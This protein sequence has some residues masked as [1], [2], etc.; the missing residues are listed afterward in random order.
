MKNISERLKK[1]IKSRKLSYGELSKLTG[2]PKSSLQRYATGSTLKVPMDVIEKIEMTL[3]L[4][5]GTLMGWE[6]LPA[7]A[8]AAPVEEIKL[9]AHE[10]NVIRSYRSKPDMQNAVDTLLGVTA[11]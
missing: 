9:T 6:E 3:H 4:K 10:T 8:A 5:A 1:E 7:D 2:I 11:D